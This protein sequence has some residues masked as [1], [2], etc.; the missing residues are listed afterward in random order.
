MVIFGGII[1]VTREIND[2]YGFHF[3][4]DKWKVL[5]KEQHLSESPEPGKRASSLPHKKDA[6]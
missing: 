1:E 3:K 5:Y 4:T 2:M 6:V